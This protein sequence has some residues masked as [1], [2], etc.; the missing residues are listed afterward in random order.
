MKDKRVKAFSLASST[1]GLT[2]LVLLNALYTPYPWIVFCI[3]AFIIWPLAVCATKLMGNKAFAFF[4]SGMVAV[5]YVALNILIAP[6]YPWSI[7][8]AF[9][10]LWYPFSLLLG[11]K[12]FAFSI[13]G[14]IWSILFFSAVNFI[15]TP[16]EIWAVYPI[17]AALWWPLSVFFFV[18]HRPISSN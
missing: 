5:Y 3:P 11:K 6:G 1:Y 7:F 8:I 18:R 15:T 2:F 17:F 10:A 16:H 9:A 4:L 12:P 14:L 13:F